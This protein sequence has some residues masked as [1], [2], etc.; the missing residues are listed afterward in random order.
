[1]RGMFGQVAGRCDLLSL[2]LDRLWR[3]RT[4][5]KLASMLADPKARVFDLCRGTSDLMQG[6]ENRR[7]AVVIGADDCY[8]M[9]IEAQPKIIQGGMR[10]VLR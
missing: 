5:S 10:A 9:L 7:V 1:M 2:N 6:L 4:M 8:P 3:A